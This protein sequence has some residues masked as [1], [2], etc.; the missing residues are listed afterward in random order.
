MSTKYKVINLDEYYTPNSEF[1]PTKPIYVVPENTVA[2]VM[3]FS[4]AGGKI[5]WEG[6]LV[7]DPRKRMLAASLTSF[8]NTLP[9]EL[10]ITR[11]WDTSISGQNILDTTWWKPYADAN[12]MF[13]YIGFINQYILPGD[14]LYWLDS[15]IALTTE[16]VAE[17][18]YIQKTYGILQMVIQETPATE[19]TG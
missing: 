13:N 4:N 11:Y 18:S 3:L 12:T 14:K 16:T 2:K 10:V 15:V 9:N 1:G 19:T 7:A 6:A 17:N 5:Y 8:V